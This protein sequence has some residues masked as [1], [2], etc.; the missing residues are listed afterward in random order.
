M[1]IVRWSGWRAELRFF[2]VTTS[3]MQETW[4]IYYWWPNQQ[5]HIYY[6]NP[7][8]QLLL[9]ICYTEPVVPFGRRRRPLIRYGPM[10]SRL[11]RVCN[12]GRHGSS[13]KELYRH[14]FF[15]R[16]RYHPLR[17]LISGFNYWIEQYRIVYRFRFLWTP[18]KWKRSRVLFCPTSYPILGTFPFPIIANLYVTIGSGSYFNIF[19]GRQKGSAC[20]PVCLPCHAS[21]AL[22]Y[23]MGSESQLGWRWE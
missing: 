22:R 18:W 13:S 8:P 17:W 2:Y 11:P 3:N 4:D 21:H 19:Y 15:I 9:L 10:I 7:P 1:D 23:E 6:S 5:M 12:F 16:R 20:L 14:S